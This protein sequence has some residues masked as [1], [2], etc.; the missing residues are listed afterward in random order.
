MRAQLIHF[1]LE[2][3]RV[4]SEDI[5]WKIEPS[6]AVVVAVKSAFEIARDRGEA[7]VSIRLHADRVEFQ[8]RHPIVMQKVPKLRQLLDER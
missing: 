2:F 3:G 7:T 6:H 5:R 1:A 4:G 8:R